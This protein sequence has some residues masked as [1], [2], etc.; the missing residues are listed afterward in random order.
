MATDPQHDRRPRGRV[1]ALWG[2]AARPAKMA[3]TATRGAKHAR[4]RHGIHCTDGRSD[5]PHRVRRKRPCAACDIEGR[6]GWCNIRGGAS[7]PI[8]IKRRFVSEPHSHAADMCIC[9][10]F[11]LSPG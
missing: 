1:L 3:E 8:V 2:G 5:G 6:I 11:G 9:W 10:P 4:V 7:R